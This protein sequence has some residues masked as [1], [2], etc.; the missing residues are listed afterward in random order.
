MG[1]PALPPVLLGRFALL[2]LEPVAN[3]GPAARVLQP[4]R[5][6][7]LPDGGRLD[8]GRHGYLCALH[9]ALVVLAAGPRRDLRADPSAV[10]PD[11]GARGRGEGAGPVQAVTQ[12]TGGTALLAAGLELSVRRLPAHRRQ[13]Q[14][15]RRRG[16][17]AGPAQGDQ[18]QLRSGG[19]RALPRLQLRAAARV[20]PE[21]LG[22][23]RL[24]LLGLAQGLVTPAGGGALG[25]RQGE[26]RRTQ[27]H[28]DRESG[29][30]QQLGAHRLLCRQAFRQ[31]VY[32]VGFGLQVGRLPLPLLQGLAVCR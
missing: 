15:A 13:V 9:D 12:A 25:Q 16:P 27:V 3:A 22:H 11:P 23:R 26:P 19:Q 24:D 21:V 28:P 1:E 6:G 14:H 17:H 20:P 4:R 18:V 32:Q 7:A 31:V 2:P 29:R 10:T 5:Q 30:G 8:L